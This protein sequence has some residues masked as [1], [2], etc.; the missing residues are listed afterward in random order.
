MSPCQSNRYPAPAVRSADIN[1]PS[2][3]DFSIQVLKL[4]SVFPTT[5][6]S[7]GNLI[8][9]FHAFVSTP[10][11]YPSIILCLLRFDLDGRFAR[12]FSL[13][14]RG[15]NIVGLARLTVLP[16][17]VSHANDGT[18]FSGDTVGLIES[19][20]K[21]TRGDRGVLV[22]RHELSPGRRHFGFPCS[23]AF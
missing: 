2:S 11:F 21:G 17:L 8:K 9:P 18:L 3:L 10:S 20:S 6:T 16:E 14:G 22:P 15:D 7:P 23:W 13:L 19:L 5:S 1:P 12:S 4:T